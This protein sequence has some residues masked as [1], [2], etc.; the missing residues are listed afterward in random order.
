[1][2]SRGGLRHRDGFMLRMPGLSASRRPGLRPSKHRRVT[3]DAMPE[4]R[5]RV[6]VR[7][8]IR[9]LRPPPVPPLSGLRTPLAAA[10]ISGHVE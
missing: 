6:T 4:Q 7:R 9:R 10:A 1:M 5:A 3:S 8:K 2:S